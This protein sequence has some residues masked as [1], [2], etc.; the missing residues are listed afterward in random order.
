MDRKCFML[1]SRHTD[2]ELTDVLQR[3]A[4]SGWMLKGNKGNTFTFKREPYHG[5]R[6]CAVTFFS[7]VPDIPT[8]KQVRQYLPVVRKKGWD[9]ICIGQPENIF[10]SRRHVFLKTS[11][12]D[13]LVPAGDPEEMAKAAK[14]GRKTALR[15]LATGLMFLAFLLFVLTNDLMMVVTST[16]YM[17]CGGIFA[18]LLAVSLVLAAV[19]I[20]VTWRKK[21]GLATGPQSYRWLDRASFWS[22]AMLLSL[23]LILLADTF[24]G[25][26]GSVGQRVRIGN[27]EV[28]LYSDTL[29][30]TLEQLGGDTSGAYRTSRYLEGG[31]P[32]AEYYYGFDE[33]LGTSASD[34]VSFISYTV[35]T[36]SHGWIR[37][38]VMA[39]E[40]ER[41]AVAQPQLAEDWK[42][43]MV[44]TTEDQLSRAVMKG[45][46]VLIFRSGFP[47]GE[48]QWT[49]VLNTLLD[50]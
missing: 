11:D 18:L 42:A 21:K 49:L 8:I 26:G 3:K 48:E 46:Q 36:S 22:M 31:S 44:Y 16:S 38:W 47:L 17:V 5:Q 20:V 33:S 13:A 6:V 24:A 28:L 14:R 7:Q 19:A 23:L 2:E 41:Q 1:L 12:P 35:F 25:E 39:Q 30:M 4:E 9:S 32:V 40:M 29:P 45:E 43:D 10:D 27:D 37:D 34:A 50:A 15:C